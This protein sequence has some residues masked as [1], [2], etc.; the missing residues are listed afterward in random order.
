PAKAA[1]LLGAEQGKGQDSS[2]QE[3][4]PPPRPAPPPPQK[5]AEPEVI[6]S[7]VR[8]EPE[9]DPNATLL[10]AREAESPPAPPQVRSGQAWTLFG[11][12]PFQP[13]LDETANLASVGEG[14]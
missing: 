7:R 8:T 6:F 11:T 12:P 5:T 2:P 14:M 1:E 10:L 9:D 13:P 4:A 3:E